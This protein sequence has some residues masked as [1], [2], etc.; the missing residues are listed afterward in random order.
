[1]WVGTDAELLKWLGDVNLKHK[2]SAD[3]RSLYYADPDANCFELKWPES[4]LR[5]S[6]FAR[7]AAMVGIDEE[8]LFNGALLWVTLSQ[9][10]SPQIEKSGWKLVEKMRQGFGENRSL[11]SA[12][13]HFFRDDELVDL[14]AFLVPCFVFGW[15]AYV[16]PHNASGD[17]FV[18]ISHNEYW[19]I[20]ARTKEAYDTLF[21]ELT[22]F[23]PKES[24]GMRKRCC[25]PASA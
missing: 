13:A 5:V 19:G 20:V 4:P 16:V 23:D 10:G 12:S 15:D 22:S 3:E 7:V 21:C 18:H 1:M 11:Q 17:Y 8:S 2:L 24:S 6:Y 9:I 25:R 14:T